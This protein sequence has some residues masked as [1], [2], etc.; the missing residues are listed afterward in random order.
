MS[1]IITVEPKSP[2]CLVDLRQDCAGNGDTTTTATTTTTTYSV[3]LVLR[4]TS[5][6]RWSALRPGVSLLIHQAVRRAW[7]VPQ[8]LQTLKQQRQQRKGPGPPDLVF[9][10]ER[11][12]QVQVVV[13][14]SMLA[15]PSAATAANHKN[16]GVKTESTRKSL[17]PQLE[18]RIVEV[19]F[20][21]LSGTH[22]A[23]HYIKVQCSHHPN[24][25]NNNNNQ[26]HNN[27]EHHVFIF[28]TYFPMDLSLRVNLQVGVEIAAYSLLGLEPG[29]VAYEATLR[30]SLIVTRQPPMVQPQQQYQQKQ[31][32][33]SGVI[34]LP[35]GRP[36]YFVPKRR[37][38]C[39][40][41][42][43]RLNIRTWL[44]DLVLPTSRHPPP[45]PWDLAALE[46][47]IHRH[48]F[49][50]TE[51]S[52]PRSTTH[53]PYASFFEC[54]VPETTRKEVDKADDAVE[55]NACHSTPKLCPLY[56]LRDDALAQLPDRLEQHQKSGFGSSFS[57]GWMGSFT[58]R[59]ANDVYTGGI[60]A[61]GEERPT[62][63]LT[64]KSGRVTVPVVLKE[65]IIM[66]QGT[67]LVVMKSISVIVSLFC[68]GKA[69]EQT[70]RRYF[71]L[72]HYSSL[73]TSS[74]IGCC[75]IFVYEGM[76]FLSSVSILGDVATFLKPN[77]AQSHTTTLLNGRD[78]THQTILQC[79]SPSVDADRS[80]NE[81]IVSHLVK[82]DLLAR[83][84]QDTGEAAHLI[85]TL[86]FEFLFVLKL[87]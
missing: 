83:S 3:I 71:D 62:A 11:A 42:W 38:T 46:D 64:L 82:S 44:E 57:A 20:V 72:P 15:N 50:P 53:N 34:T 84:S 16:A 14:S 24:D 2:F 87:S 18:G 30:S 74:E 19:H 45:P 63:G 37:R 52:P 32:W 6:Q 7:R 5:L 43:T 65:E 56:S 77:G 66:Q 27:P 55:S 60:I 12:D 79:V 68:L 58:L 67:R 61:L 10:V 9:V 48:V 40:E 78:R 59:C 1:P 41:A 69:P 51:V 4:Q 13:A 35:F 73:D 85:M 75:R 80:F 23:V 54:H 49:G 26:A 33:S 70:N 31:K 76:M 36:F 21:R 39:Q 81:Q 86:S 17:V 25:N 47:S 29:G 28:L 22:T 8:W